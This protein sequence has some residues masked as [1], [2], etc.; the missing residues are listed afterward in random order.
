[1]FNTVYIVKYL[2]KKLGMLEIHTLVLVSIQKQKLS[3][4]EQF[5]PDNTELRF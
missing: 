1:M 2:F 4:S 5:D 3:V